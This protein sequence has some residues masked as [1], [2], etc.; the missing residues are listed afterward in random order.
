MGYPVRETDNYSP[1]MHVVRDENVSKPRFIRTT[2]IALLIGLFL[3]PIVLNSIGDIAAI[4]ETDIDWS[5]PP[6]SPSELS[7]DWV[8]VTPE[9]MKQRS[10]RRE[11]QY[12]E[13]DIKIAFDKGVHGKA[14]YRGRDHWHIYNPNGTSAR[15]YYLDKDGNAIHKN[16]DNSHIEVN[17]K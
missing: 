11:F 13:T 2:I 12:R 1:Q 16:D 14:R 15:D 17:C 7:S 3:V 5:K 10:Q 9:M 8:E 4:P 6:C